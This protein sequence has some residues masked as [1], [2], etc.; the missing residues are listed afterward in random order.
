MRK[1]L[2][3]GCNGFL[4]RKLMEILPKKFDVVGTDVFFNNEEK[5]LIYL[6]ITN[7]EEVRK[8]INN[9]DPDIVI[10]TSAYTNVDLCETDRERAKE[11]NVL[12]VRNVVGCCKNR[13][14]LFYSTDST[15]GEDKKIPYK[16]EDEQNPLNYYGQTKLEGEKIVKTL[17]DYLICRTCM[18]YSE[19][20]EQPKFVNYAIKN[21]SEGNSINAINNLVA[22]PTST[23]DLSR[24]TLELLEKNTEGIY[25]VA[26]ASFLTPYEMALTIADVF[27]FDKSLITPITMESLNRP[28]RR[29]KNAMLDTTKLN[30]EGIRMSTFQEG[31]RKIREQLNF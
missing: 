19:N 29:S 12:G 31:I 21:L 20:I 1:I 3:I 14:L 22:T 16:E 25:H 17:K 30:S 28:A 13:K 11:I 27:N 10:L 18:L 8:V 26:G 4:G 5:G 9:L 15:F 2:I 23:H 6:D 24:A 7:K